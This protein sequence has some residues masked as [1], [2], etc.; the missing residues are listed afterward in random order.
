[1]VFSFHPLTDR[2]TAHLLHIALDSHLSHGTYCIDRNAADAYCHL[3]SV[4]LQLNAQYS[5]ERI[6]GICLT[7]LALPQ[8]L[9]QL[10]VPRRS[11]NK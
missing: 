3:L 10:V 11:D 4:E 5:R 6:P 2:I 1:M 9:P 8:Y 7:L